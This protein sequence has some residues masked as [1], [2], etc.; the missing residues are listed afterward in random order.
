MPRGG[1]RP[2]SGGRRL[3]AG[4]RK[5][6]PDKEKR[7]AEIAASGLTPLDYALSVLR[8]EE[9]APDDRKWAAQTAMPFCHHRLASVEHTGKDG[10]PIRTEDARVDALLN[11]LKD[12]DLEALAA[13]ARRFTNGAGTSRPH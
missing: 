10:G 1:P 2:N 3:G 11:V 13:I 8:D 9:A 5:G 6:S 12:D 7:V 4:R